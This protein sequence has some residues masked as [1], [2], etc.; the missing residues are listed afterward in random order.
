M[1][2]VLYRGRDQ[3]VDGAA[4]VSRVREATGIR[5]IHQSGD[6]ALLVEFEGSADALRQ[7]AGG[8]VGWSVSESKT[9]NLL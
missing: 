1:Q 7:L 6:R 4:D 5:V 8:L 3:A 2:Y 9:Y